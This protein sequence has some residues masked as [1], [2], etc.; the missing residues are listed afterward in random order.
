MIRF[1]ETIKFNPRF[2]ALVYKL[3]YNPDKGKCDLYWRTKF[4][5]R[6]AQGT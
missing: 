6:L 1:I 4:K 3:F 5:L 2:I